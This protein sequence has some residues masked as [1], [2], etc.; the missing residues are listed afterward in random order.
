MQRESAQNEK[1]KEMMQMDFLELNASHLKKKKKKEKRNL[2]FIDWLVKS[3]HQS[4]DGIYKPSK[5]LNTLSCTERRAENIRRHSNRRRDVYTKTD[6][7][8]ER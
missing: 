7:P 2:R 1:K 3:S 4:G 6:T 5:E 8:G